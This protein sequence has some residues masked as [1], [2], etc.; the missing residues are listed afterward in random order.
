M[1]LETYN[2]A[3][4]ATKSDTVNIR[5]GLTGA[6]QCGEAGT[7]TVVFQDDTTAVF[8]VAAGNI[9]PVKVKRINSTGTAGTL[10]VALYQSVPNS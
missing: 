5:Q 7:V 9:L 4:A 2:F 3:F 6:I 8:T 10:F 1:A